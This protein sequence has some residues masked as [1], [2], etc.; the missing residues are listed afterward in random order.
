[1]DLDNKKSAFSLIE[2]LIVIGIISILA[3]LLTSNLL[4]T[5]YQNNL[6]GDASKIAA[7][8]RAARDKSITQENSQQ[9]GVHFVNS[10]TSTDYY[11]LFGGPSFSSSTIISRVNLN[12]DVVFQNPPNSSSTDIIFQKMTGLPVATSSI[13]ISLMN[14]SSNAM[15]ISI[16]SSGEV[17]Y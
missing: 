15:T 7:T 16:I 13:I 1:M 12:P 4:N 5:F 9:W 6:K 14:N 17:Q 11:V 8:L 10:S 3:T 2:L